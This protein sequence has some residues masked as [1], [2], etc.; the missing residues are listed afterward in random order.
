MEPGYY[1]VLMIK[2][3]ISFFVGMKIV[4]REIFIDRLTLRQAFAFTI[5]Y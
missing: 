5:G 1:F 3:Y 2:L 4:S